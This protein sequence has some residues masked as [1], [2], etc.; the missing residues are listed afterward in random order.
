MIDFPR[1]HKIIRDVWDNKP[2]TILT[3]LAITV[4]VFA[5]GGMFIDDAFARFAKIVILI[6][7]AAVLVMSQDHMAKLGILKFEDAA[8]PFEEL[9]K[10]HEEIEPKRAAG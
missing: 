1:L 4:G 9:E 5:F 10:S 8:D 3:V 6:S 2:R 7:A